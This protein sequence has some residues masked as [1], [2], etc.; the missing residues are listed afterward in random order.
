[1]YNKI[2]EILDEKGRVKT[3][4]FLDGPNMGKKCILKPETVIR[5]ENK[6]EGEEKK[7]GILLISENPQEESIW[8]PYLDI[9]KGDPGNKSDGCIWLPPFCRRLS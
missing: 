5:R 9:L 1:M 4:I 3:G 7:S 6:S 2:Y 8:F